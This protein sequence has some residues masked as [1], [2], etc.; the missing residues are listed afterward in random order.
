MKCSYKTGLVNL[1]DCGKE[2]N[3]S[4]MTCDRPVCAEHGIK[5]GRGTQCQE[6]FARQNPKDGKSKAWNS[7]R[8]HRFYDGYSYMPIYFGHRGTY[9]SEEYRYFDPAVAT[10]PNYFTGKPDEADEA[11]DFDGDEDVMDP[12]D[13]NDS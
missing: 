13:F 6:C 11:G 9:G 3:Q 1:R 7:F 5:T 4:C 12:S 8:R 2:T 10:D